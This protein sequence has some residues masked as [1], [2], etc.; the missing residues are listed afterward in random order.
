MHKGVHRVMARLLRVDLGS[1]ACTFEDLA[2][3]QAQLGGHA[4]TSWA[5]EQL[6]PPEAD[7]LGPEN[8][9][10]VAAGVLAGTAV[11]NSGRLSVGCKSPLTGGIKE[12]NSG[13]SVARKMARLG[14][15]GIIVTGKAPGPTTLEIDAKGARL[16]WAMELWGKGTAQ[17][18]AELRAAQG[19]DIGIVTIG[20]A[21]EKMLKASA[22]VV[23]TPDFY[24]RTASRGGVGAV[25]GSKNLKAIVVNDKGG[26]GVPLANPEL[27]KSAA[28][29]LS[30]GIQAH[31][32]MGALGALGSAFLLMAAQS[33]G[34]L[35]T[36]SFSQGQFEK[37]EAIS[38]EAMAG[39]MAQRPNSQPVHR[40]MPGC[41]VNCSQ[42]FTDEKG[43]VVTSGFEYETLG[44]LGSNCM[45]SDL[46]ALARMNAL[47]DDIG[48]DTMDVGAAVGV[49]M[50]AGKIA[51]GD[52]AAVEKLLADSVKGNELGELLA[53][54]A[55]ATG[56][57][58]GVKRI[59]VVKGQ[60]LAA[61]EPR[62]LKGTGVTYCTSPQG[63]DHTAGNA[64]P[65]PNYDPTVPQG[66]AQMSQF[67]QAYFAAL[68]TLGLC[69]FPGLALLDNMPLFN[70]LA[71]AVV[72][73]T[74][75]QVS[76]ENYL[77]RLGMGVLMGE[78]AFNRAAGF[79][80]E[81]DRL[82]DYFWKDPLPPS[83]L[84]FDVATEDIDG[85]FA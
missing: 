8:I 25:M 1:G 31:G 59:P 58:L 45:I 38:G 16:V 18:F 53:N 82:P 80:R 84:V 63:A 28:S 79:T 46:D 29:E 4:F 44:L 14:I 34:C 64:I 33:M 75:Q 26:S 36:K 51:W 54:G 30:A 42:V 10:A 61:W 12:A 20:P 3:D 62:F 39:L 21:G 15:R 2:S 73:V 78:V 60:S 27:M 57:A 81:D 67:L 41:V 68:D 23:S 24:P 70:K 5:V 48:L 66:Q 71:D 11:P 47:L 76:R 65:N 77:V 13:G 22:V 7:P 56:E 6:V 55:K 85:V 69:L 74:G 9:F 19:D 17:V 40:C 35:A 52:A 43:E 37:A 83:G 50:E 49:A 72:A 32:A